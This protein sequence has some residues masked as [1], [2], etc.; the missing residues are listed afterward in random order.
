MAQCKKCNDDGYYF[1]SK[2]SDVVVPCKCTE[3]ENDEVQN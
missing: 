1:L 2:N 3:K